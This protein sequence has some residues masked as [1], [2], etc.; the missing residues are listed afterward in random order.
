MKTGVITPVLGAMLFAAACG[1]GAEPTAPEPGDPRPSVRFFNAMTAM[2]GP[3][4]FTTNGQF[5]SGSALG[6]SQSTATCT[7]LD[8]GSASFG[9]GAA[10]TGGT[11]LS[12]GTLATSNNQSIAA[13]GNYTVAAVGSGVHALLFLI[14]N[15]F[16]G[17]L[18]SNQAAVRFVNLAPA[19]NPHTVLS[20]TG[21]GSTTTVASNLAL[22]ASSTFTTV[23]SGSN[24]YTVVNGS[25]TIVSGSAGTLNL[26]AGTVN[27]IA[28]VPGTA[29][30]T[31]QLINIPRC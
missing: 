7:K 1:G 25:N 13:S 17:S 11:G 24:A 15:N 16:S 28:M 9:F 30:G 3:G 23:T 31:F 18:G 20:G 19:M 29:A 26:Q 5:V 21:S 4:G 2:P 14:D 12:G 10:N 27:T 8:A 6:F 22:G